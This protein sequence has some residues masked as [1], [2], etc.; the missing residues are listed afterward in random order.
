M[1]ES[2]SHL[3]NS[4]RYL[5]ELGVS[6]SLDSDCGAL[7]HIQQLMLGD[8]EKLRHS[9]IIVCGKDGCGKSTLLSQVIT[10]CTEWLGGD[11]IRIVRHVGQSPCSTYT[12]ELLRNLCLHISLAFDFSPKHHSYELGEL[13]IWFQDLLK[14]VE[15]TPTDL[16]IVL[17]DLH[18]LRSPASN[19]SAI[20]GWLPWNLPPNVHVVVSISEEAEGVLRLLRSRSSTGDNFVHI[21]DLGPS[22]AISMLQSNLKD[23]K[24]TLT[25][26]QMQ[27]IKT[28]LAQTSPCPLYIKLLSRI[29]ETWHSW[30][31]ISE[32]TIPSKLEEVVDFILTG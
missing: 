8:D 10:Y 20:L 21:P 19:Q 29:A 32:L 13:S 23:R 7:L 12:S 16:V 3:L 30:M 25:T 9:P 14:M 28:K 1:R 5:R 24:H 17:D 6:Q 18:E 15:E 11:V 26:E 31:E 4:R 2:Q 27:A 22:A